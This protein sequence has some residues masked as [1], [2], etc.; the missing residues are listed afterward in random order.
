MPRGTEIRNVIVNF[1]KDV[2]REDI[3]RRACRAYSK[4]LCEMYPP[5]AIDRMIEKL[6]KEVKS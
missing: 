4:I 2:S 3:E 6:R 1:P 5:E